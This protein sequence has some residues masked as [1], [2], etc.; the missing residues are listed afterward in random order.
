VL[1]IVTPGGKENDH[2]P[3]GEVTRIGAG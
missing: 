1:W 2:F 3:F